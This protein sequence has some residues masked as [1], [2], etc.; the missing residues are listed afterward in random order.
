M[1]WL[2]GP[3][4]RRSRRN[5]GKSGRRGSQ[6]RC[7]HGLRGEGKGWQRKQGLSLGRLRFLPTVPPNPSPAGSTGSRDQAP[8]RWLMDLYSPRLSL[9]PSAISLWGPLSARPEHKS[10]CVLVFWG[11]V[12]GSRCFWVMSWGPHSLVP[13]ASF[14]SA[15][16]SL[17]KGLVF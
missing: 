14:T 10:A 12:Q 5:W 11:L 1:W 13:H 7:A 3:Q 9:A 16:P 2:A 4:A 17:F 6:G 8:D 15:C